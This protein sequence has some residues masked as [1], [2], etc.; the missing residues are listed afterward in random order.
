MFFLACTECKFNAL[1]QK[2]K[3]ITTI[4]AQNRT[5]K[6]SPKSVF[7]RSLTV[8]VSE[9]NHILLTATDNLSGLLWLFTYTI[10]T[11]Q[12]LTFLVEKLLI[13]MVF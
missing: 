8:L 3:T 13:A 7:V 9:V 10:S 12:I 2:F 11:S 6:T 1:E 4:K 5:T